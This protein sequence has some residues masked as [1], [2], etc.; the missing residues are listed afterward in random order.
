VPREVHYPR[1][2]VR[3]GISHAASSAKDRNKDRAGCP[4]RLDRSSRLRIAGARHGEQ[5]RGQ[6]VIDQPGSAPPR[7]GSYEVPASGHSQQTP[8]RADAVAASTTCRSSTNPERASHAVVAVRLCLQRQKPLSHCQPPARRATCTQGRRSDDPS[9]AETVRSQRRWTRSPPC[10][11]SL[12]TLRPTTHS[13]P[14][15]IY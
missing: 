7:N 8:N 14:Q 6:R 12:R 2:G 9:S 3:G 11:G 13:N 1:P 4:W 5:R 15:A 10:S